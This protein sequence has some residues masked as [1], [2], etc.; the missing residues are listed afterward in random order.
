[1]IIDDGKGIPKDVLP[2]IFE[3]FFSTKKSGKN[4]GLGLSV[5]YGIIKQHCGAIDVE[6]KEGEDAKFTITLPR[7][8]AA[9]R[10]V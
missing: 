6:S 7:L 2:H 10:N 8:P 9:K 5:V 1:M 4:T 3:P